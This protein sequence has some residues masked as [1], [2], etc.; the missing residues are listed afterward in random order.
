M[1]SERFGESSCFF[2]QCSTAFSADGGNRRAVKGLFP[3][4]GLPRVFLGITIFDFGI[5]LYNLK[6]SRGEVPTSRSALTQATKGFK[7]AQ[8][9]SKNS[10]TA[11]RTMASWFQGTIGDRRDILEGDDFRNRLV[12]RV[13]TPAF[14]HATAPKAASESTDSLFSLRTR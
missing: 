4:A 5:N 1:A 13:E 9:G 10:I 6:A 12:A 3:V 2:A 8:A 7:M 11:P 14:A